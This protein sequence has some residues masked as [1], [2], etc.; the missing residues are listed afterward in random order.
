MRL[1]IRGASTRAGIT[2]ALNFLPMKLSKSTITL[3]V[4]A[5]LVSVYLAMHMAVQAA[6]FPQASHSPRAHASTTAYA[7]TGNA[8]A[9]RIVATSTREA[10]T[11]T[12]P[13]TANRLGVTLQTINCVSGGAVWIQ[14]ND[15]HAT[16]S[17]GYW[18]AA[19]STAT[20]AD[21]VPNV[22]GSIRAS[23]SNAACTLLVTEWRSEN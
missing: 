8:T 11:A 13:A 21:S 20:F 7:L 12:L 16:T 3:G 4:L 17:T 18:L 22:Y 15:V 19:S 14:F 9:T 2:I 1:E 6:E 23:A 5:L 10:A